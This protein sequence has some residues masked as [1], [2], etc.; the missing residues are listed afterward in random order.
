MEKEINIEKYK[1]SIICGDAYEVLKTFPDE[2][3]D[4]VITSPPLEAKG[5][6][7]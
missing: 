6:W 4:C 3:V 2:C 1:N 7:Y 5:L